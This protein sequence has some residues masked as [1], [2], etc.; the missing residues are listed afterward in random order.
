MNLNKLVGP[1]VAAVNPWKLAT[2]QRSTGAT[3]AADGGQAPT[4]ARPLT[5]RVQK[6]ALGWKD[7]TQIQGLN[8]NGEKCAMY[9]DGD[10]QGVSRPRGRGA[11]LVTLADDGS[12]WLVV[13][14]LENWNDTDGW[15]KV[16]CVLQNGA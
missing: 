12:V 3:T 8:I 1:I 10:W 11:D 2:Y 13:Q 7:L 9:V 5:V 16:A 4:Y 15:V 14:V 6:Q